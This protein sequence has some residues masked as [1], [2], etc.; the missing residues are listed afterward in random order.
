MSL[1]LLFNS[2]PFVEPEE[3]DTACAHSD[4]A[5]LFHITSYSTLTNPIKVN[6]NTLHGVSVTHANLYSCKADIEAC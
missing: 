4:A 6:S 3:V 5:A 2:A 1:L